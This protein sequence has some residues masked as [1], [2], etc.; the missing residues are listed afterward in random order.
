MSPG[1][2]EKGMAMRATTGAFTTCDASAC[3]TSCSV[4]GCTSQKVSVKSNGVCA[5][6]QKFAYS[7][8]GR[9]ASPGSSGT[10][11]KLI[12]FDMTS[13]SSH[14]ADDDSLDLNL[15]GVEMHRLHG[16]IR[17]LQPD[18]AG[19]AIELLQGDVRAADQRDD[20]LAV[21]GGLAV[22]DDDEVAVTDL[23]VDHRV[24]S[25]PENVA[26]ALAGEV[27]GYRD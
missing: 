26:V 4:S 9:P 14:D 20:H 24:A 13:V 12:C 1:T 6:A 5:T 17:G 10:I 25:D 27:L 11:V 23:F 2:T 3:R 16:G 22:L 15:R 19:L 18:T 21:V 8:T 7:R